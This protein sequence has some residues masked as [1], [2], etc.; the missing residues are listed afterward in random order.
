M[1]TG[2]L[3]GTMIGLMTELKTELMMTYGVRVQKY[4][5]QLRI[6]FSSKAK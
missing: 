3:T 4:E 5:A 2:T 6:A 1:L